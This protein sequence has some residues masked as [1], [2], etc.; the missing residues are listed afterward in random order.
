[1]PRLAPYQEPGAG[2]RA[3]N[4]TGGREQGSQLGTIMMTRGEVT[5]AG[6]RRVAGEMWRSRRVLDVFQ[7]ICQWTGCRSEIN[8]RATDG[9]RISGPRREWTDTVRP[10]CS[11]KS[12][13]ERGACGWRGESRGGSALKVQPGESRAHCCHTKPETGQGHRV[14]DCKQNT[15][16][17]QRL[18]PARAPHSFQLREA[19]RKQK[20]RAGDR[21]AEA[22]GGLGPRGRGRFKE[23]GAANCVKR[24]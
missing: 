7:R 21:G 23:G 18:S 2:C 3:E 22:R 17:V 8:A 10:R 11:L 13:V 15:E 1:M 14:S 12:C 6:P 9:A 20:E 16:E 24:Q 4:T 5:V 19:E